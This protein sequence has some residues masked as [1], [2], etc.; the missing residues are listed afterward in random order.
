MTFLDDDLPIAMAKRA[1]APPGAFASTWPGATDEDVAGMLSDGFASARL[2]GFFPTHTF[3]MSLYQVTPD[4][5]DAGLALVV[6]YMAVN[7]LQSKILTM[8]TATRYKS[9]PVEAEVTP[10]ATV[11]TNLLN[12]STGLISS[13]QKGTAGFAP[14]FTDGLTLAFESDSFRLAANESPTSAPYLRF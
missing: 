13:L 7:S 5:T 14:A 2:A 8:A 9:G 3:D 1:L 10:L 6:A 12:Q 4:L 11:L